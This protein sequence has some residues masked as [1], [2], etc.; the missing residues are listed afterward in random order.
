MSPAPP[1]PPPWRSAASTSGRIRSSS[2]GHSPRPP[3]PSRPLRRRPPSTTSVARSSPSPRG[4]PLLAPPPP[5]APHQNPARGRGA[6]RRPRSSRRCT[7]SSRSLR[8][9]ITISIRSPALRG[10]NARKEEEGR[11]ENSDDTIG[12]VPGTPEEHPGNPTRSEN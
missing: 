3:N 10:D 5:P 2:P 6:T 1:P 4:A 11:E 12:T 8:R 9:S 7:I